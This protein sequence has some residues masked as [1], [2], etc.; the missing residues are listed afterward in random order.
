MQAASIDLHLDQNYQEINEFTYLEDVSG[1]LDLKAIK[2]KQDWQ[3]LTADAFNQGFTNSTWWVKLEINNHNN[4]SLKRLMEIGYPILDY[5]TVYVENEQGILISES[6]LGDKYVFSE[7]EIDHRNFII[8]LDLAAQEKLSVYFKLKSQGS[9]QLPITIWK[10]K[11]FYSADKTRSLVFGIYY[12]IMIAMVLYNLFLFVKVRE[13]SYIYYVLWVLAMVIIMAGFNGIAF[14][15][16][17]PKATVWNDQALPF[18]MNACLLF[19]VFFAVDFLSIEWSTKI[20]FVGKTFIAIALILMLASFI[21]PYTYVIR[22]TVVFILFT[23]IFASVIGVHFWREENNLGKYYSF[24]W[25]VLA[26]GGVILGLSKANYLP[27]NFT[28]DYALQLGTVMQVIVFSFGLGERINLEK[29]LLYVTQAKLLENEK[30][31][32][33]TQEQALETQKRTNEVLEQRVE[34]RTRELQEVNEA[35]KELSE[36]DKLTGL[37]NR[38]FLD[39]QLDKEISHCSK[40]DKSLSVLLMDIDHFK[41]FNDKYGHLLGDKC[42]QE[43]AQKIESCVNKDMDCA[44]RFGGEEFCVVLPDTSKEGAV[45]VAERI[46]KAV[47]NLVLVFEDEQIKVT[48]SIGAYSTMPK[49]DQEA[50]E[51]LHF[52]DKAL[53]ASKENGR[54]QVTFWDV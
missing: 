51:L 1:Q 31:L 4:V 44:A 8:P 53:Y 36:T 22:I 54:N 5:L 15:Y 13:K 10:N 29:K 20:G 35:L 14:Q 49:L 45:A 9:L 6:V 52:A 50:T 18:F 27:K 32:R 16:L 7:R 37:K 46:R 2:Q 26:V 30:Q 19:G 11:N 48:I 41:S 17:W 3:E 24:A 40:W 43:V 12:G 21:F 33:E 39:A 47:E 28:T 34:E 42:L 25:A 23:M 38:A